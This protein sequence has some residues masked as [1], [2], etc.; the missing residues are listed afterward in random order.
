MTAEYTLP[1]DLVDKISERLHSLPGRCAAVVN[2]GKQTALW[3]AVILTPDKAQALRDRAE[4]PPHL[5]RFSTIVSSGIK[6]IGVGQTWLLHPNEGQWWEARECRDQLGI[7]MP[8][9]W[10]LR[11]FGVHADIYKQVIAR[12]EP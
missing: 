1:P 2:L 11:L 10:Q 8:D 4:V 12:Y 5:L 9:G 6:D 3:N 7:E